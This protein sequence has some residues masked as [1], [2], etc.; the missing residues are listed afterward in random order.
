[1]STLRHLLAEEG[2]TRSAAAPSGKAQE[3]IMAYL[4]NPQVKGEVLLTDMSKDPSFRGIHFAKI[5]SAMQA[6]AK[7]GLITHREQK[8][9]GDFLAKK[10]TSKTSIDWEEFAKP[11][12]T[13]VWRNYNTIGPRRFLKTMIQIMESR[14][15]ANWLITEDPATVAKVEAKWGRKSYPVHERGVQGRTVT[16]GFKNLFFGTLAGKKV[17]VMVSDFPLGKI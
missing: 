16:Q 3:A 6:L 9:E 17:A 1:M 5:M 14:L 7:K 11:L 4:S 12:E 2:L 8:G 15:P 13:Q 10:A